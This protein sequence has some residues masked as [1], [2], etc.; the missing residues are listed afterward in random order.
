MALKDAEPR[1]LYR[2]VKTD[3]PT[4]DDLRSSAARGRPRPLDPE[5]A[6]LHDGISAFAT[7]TQAVAKARSY[8][9]LG[10]FVAELA[11]LR[12]SPV[13]IERTI[14][15]SRGHHTIWGD[16]NVLLDCVV[17][18]VPVFVED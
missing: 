18:V 4:L 9:T 16:P 7:L 3:P 17:R 1:R 11:I 5:M 15:R 14:P 6:R 12:S 2:I 10:R 8:Q 13:R